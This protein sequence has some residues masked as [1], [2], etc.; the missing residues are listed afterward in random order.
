MNDWILWLLQKTWRMQCGRSGRSGL[1]GES[2]SF[3]S[4][5]ERNTRRIGFRLILCVPL[6]ALDPLFVLLNAWLPFCL[7]LDRLEGWKTARGIGLCPPGDEHGAYRSAG[8]YGRSSVYLV[9]R[10]T[11]R[12]ANQ[13]TRR[14]RKSNARRLSEGE[15]EGCIGVDSGDRGLGHF[16]V[17]IAWQTEY[18][19]IYVVVIIM[20]SPSLY[21]L[22]PHQRT[23]LGEVSRPP[24][25][26]FIVFVGILVQ[27]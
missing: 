27:E 3:S 1:G 5:L 24:A 11:F 25:G 19:F 21:G 10:C 18:V 22:Y 23:W 4:I 2:L 7:Y 12:R 8:E 14:N 20:L 17:R 26:T 13:S 9:C 16:V 6:S 15:I